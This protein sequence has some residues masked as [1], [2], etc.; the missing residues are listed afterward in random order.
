MRSLGP[1]T[2]RA[3]TTLWPASRRGA[4]TDTTPSSDSWR[5]SAKP[6]LRIEASSDPSAA[7]SV[8]V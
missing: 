2:L 8:M 7:W 6:F 4:A 1:A 5:F 3:A